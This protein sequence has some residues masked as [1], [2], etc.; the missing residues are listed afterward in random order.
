MR[1]AE[2]ITFEHL[3]V[4]AKRVAIALS[5]IAFMASG[6]SAWAYGPLNHLCVANRNWEATWALIQAVDPKTSKSAA[7]QA[8]FAGAMADDLGY[9][10]VPGAKDLK[11]LTDAMHYARTGEWVAVQLRLAAA[12]PNGDIFAFALGEL[13]HYAADRMGHYY[14]TNAVAVRIAKRQSMYGPRMSY[15]RDE[16]M[17][18]AVESGFDFIAVN[19]GCSPDDIEEIARNLP[20]GRAWDAVG[21]VVS[22]LNSQFQDRFQTKKFELK[23]EYFVQALLIADYLFARTALEAETRLYHIQPSH[24]VLPELIQGFEA[25]PN[26]QGQSRFSDWAAERVQDGLTFLKDY[27]EPTVATFEDSFWRANKLYTDL[28]SQVQANEDQTPSNLSGISFPNINLDTN[29]ESASGQYSLADQTY[30]HILTLQGVGGKISCP[31]R[32]VGAAFQLYFT[33]GHSDRRRLQKLVWNLPPGP[34]LKDALRDIGTFLRQAYKVTSKDPISLPDL[35]SLKFNNCNPDGICL[36]RSNARI[37]LKD[38]NIGIAPGIVNYTPQSTLLDVWLAALAANLLTRPN[39][40]I[41]AAHDVEEMRLGIIEDY[42][43]D[44]V[45]NPDGY[46]GWPDFCSGSPR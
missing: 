14:G 35:D 5:A 44:D 22:F 26:N 7:R 11:L 16:P 40:S 3:S 20:R 27:G 36:E 39:S 33:D 10:P 37:F 13:A 24:S 34:D 28:L 18:F 29:M 42:R 2:V 9:Y 30:E 21:H 4:A 43:L 15:E 38:A 8:F 23:E 6:T 12:A 17:H 32:N 46:Y 25:S 45:A 1:I 41:N 19:N 31:P